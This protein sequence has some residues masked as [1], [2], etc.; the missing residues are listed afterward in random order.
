MKRLDLIGRKFNRLKVIEFSCAKNGN[1][2]WKCLCD[3]GKICIVSACSLKN[4]DTTSCG[5]IKT[6]KYAQGESG[7]KCLYV[8]YKSRAKKYERSFNLTLKEF[9]EITSKN[10]NY[11]GKKPENISLTRVN[12][13]INLTKYKSY[14]YNG[15]DRI[16]SSKGYEKR[17]IV[18]CCKWC[19]IAKGNKTVKEFK[20]H[21]F[22]MHNVLNTGS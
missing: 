7:L 22:K 16:D 12:K 8:I 1:S 15:I 14:I 5:C 2:Y 6:Y 10:C 17:N 19:N 13:D 18:P 20:E 4:N 3:C 9:K 21:I 11:C